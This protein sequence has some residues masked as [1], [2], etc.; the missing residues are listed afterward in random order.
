[1]IGKNHCATK[2]CSVVWHSNGISNMK[3]IKLV[4]LKSGLL[5]V[6]VLSSL[7]LLAN[8]SP[9][10]S[11]EA[12]VDASAN[13]CDQ[14]AAQRALWDTRLVS[15]AI[16]YF[17]NEFGQ[18]PDE[19]LGLGVLVERQLIHELPLDPWQ[20]AYKY[21]F[22]GSEARKFDFYSLGQNGVDELGQGDDIGYWSSIE[23]ASCGALSVVAWITGFLFFLTFV[24]FIGFV[25][26]KRKARV[27]NDA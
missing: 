1:M 18:A 27:Q 19:R 12:S 21:R 23:S 20:R 5:V 22:P 16:E 4:A 2:N 11:A 24:A 7:A 14:S 6:G 17:A 13:A 3:L 10:V 9:D 8:T 26:S 15:G 25:I